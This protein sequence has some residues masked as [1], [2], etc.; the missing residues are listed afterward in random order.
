VRGEFRPDGRVASGATS[1]CSAS[2]AAGHSPRCAARSSRSSRT[3][4][5]ASSRRGTTS[6]ASAADSRRSSRRSASSRAP[7][8]SRARSRR[9]CSRS[10][11]AGTVPPTSTSCARRARSCGSGRVDRCVDGRV[12]LYFAD[13]LP[14]LARRSN[15]PIRPTVRCTTHPP[16]ARAARRELLEPAPIGDA[17]LQRRRGARRAV[18]PR[19]GGGGHERHAR[20]VA[21]RVDGRPCS[22][23]VV[24][25]LRG[26]GRATSPT[27]AGP[28]H[29]HRP[30]GRS[31]S[32]EPRRAADGAGPCS[33]RRCAR[34]RAA[35]ARALRRRSLARQCSPRASSAGYSSVYGV[36]K[37]LE[38]RGQ[39][40][41]GYFVTGLGA[42]QFS[43][44]VPSI[45]CAAC[46]RQ[47]TPSCTPRPCRRR[48]CSPRPTRRSRTA[49]R[50]RGRIHRAVRAQRR[51]AGRPPQRV[52][53][54]LVRPALHH[55]VSFPGVATAT[56]GR[57][58]SHAR[59]GRAGR[60]ASRSAS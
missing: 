42:A 46:V 50:C 12:R 59:E 57:R 38:E 19:V 26:E 10:A 11:C 15:G 6:R 25:R 44:P 27:P 47:R 37:V 21:L 58:R 48:S 39:A 29:P 56:R 60:R 5:S 8:S 34:V 52:P 20:A 43:L 22:H 54:G 49:R 9:T 36:L 24:G 33:H 17:W 41:R 13:Q 2:C 45:A 40:R 31:R 3:P 55:L 18:G 35:D 14:L 53:A 23:D 16:A 30:A 4:T 28:A 7:P 51:R 1:M 32:V